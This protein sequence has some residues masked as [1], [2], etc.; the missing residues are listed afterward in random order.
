MI[1]CKTTGV[2]FLHW[3]SVTESAL[4]KVSPVYSKSSV[5]FY[6]V[7]VAYYSTVELCKHH[8]QVHLNTLRVKL[9]TL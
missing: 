4:S 2:R 9:G 7:G 8:T 5:M 6:T 1:Y 3:E